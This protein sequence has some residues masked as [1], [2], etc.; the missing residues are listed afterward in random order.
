MRIKENKE[1]KFF[2]G[3]ANPRKSV[4]AL[5]KEFYGSPRSTY[6]ALDALEERG[7]IEI[8][9]SVSNKKQLIVTITEKGRSP[10]I[11]YSELIMI[12]E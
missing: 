11:N 6:N 3:L 7:L 12:G 5:G 1:I 8:D 4:F 9:S 10:I 2:L